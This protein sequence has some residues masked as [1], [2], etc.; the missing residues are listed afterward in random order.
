M[1]DKSVEDGFGMLFDLFVSSI[2]EVEGGEDGIV[3]SANLSKSY[4]FFGMTIEVVVFLFAAIWSLEV[5]VVV[6]V[7]FVVVVVGF[8]L[9]LIE[10]VVELSDKLVIVT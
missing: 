3:S 4:A 1:L 10:L 5:V 7:V 6:D 9:D 2:V 8:L